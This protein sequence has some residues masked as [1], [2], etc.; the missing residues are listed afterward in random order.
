M[1]GVR[2]GEQDSE[3]KDEGELSLGTYERADGRVKNITKSWIFA[4]ALCGCW[5]P[6]RG[7]V[8]DID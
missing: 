7:E 1:S 4:P 2:M 5:Y 8:S 6:W 3:S